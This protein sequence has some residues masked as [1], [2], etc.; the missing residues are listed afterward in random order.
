[1]TRPAAA[2]ARFR[3]RLVARDATANALAE[4]AVRS[5]VRC[6]PGA[7]V[8]LV[9]AND[10]SVFP[11]RP[12][13]LGANVAAVHVP[14]HDDEVARAVGR[15][16]REHLFYWRH[17][18]T[19]RAALPQTDRYEVYTDTDI[20][21][22][23]PM[24]LQSLLDPLARGRIAAAVDE[25]TLDHYERLGTLAAAPASALLPAAG[26]GGP[27]VQAGLVFTNPD[28]DGGLYDLFWDFAER[29]AAMGVLPDLPS[30]DMC[31]LT[32]LLGQG[33]PLWERLLLL[34]HEW[35]YITDALKDPG[36]FGC[37]AHYGGHRAKAFL[38]AQADRLFG[39]HDS[40]P[41]SSPWGTAGAGSSRAPWPSEDARTVEV[42]AP[43][44]LT[45]TVPDGADRLLLSAE[46]AGNL[47]RNDTAAFYLY[48]DGR[49]VRRVAQG[50]N[51][52]RAQVPLHGSETVT[53]LGTAS[54]AG[55]LVRLDDPFDDAR[56]LVDTTEGEQA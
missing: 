42:C 35:N 32:A 16:S 53:V 4:L 23:R 43:F 33:G 1:M 17:S 31:I 26:A 45:W 11:P 36:V 28:D 5:L 47:D 20:V 37:A 19:L 34:G 13:G 10:V 40:R 44:A 2:S 24:D 7:D 49:L 22:L 51:R 27:L 18:P 3:F 50:G 30:D 15:A 39:T 48:L 25:S 14:P 54:T 8:L 6:H 56:L 9:D 38:R 29:A 12:F 41:S 46:L 52:A 55:V 21:F